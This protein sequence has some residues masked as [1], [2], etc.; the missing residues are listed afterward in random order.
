MPSYLRRRPRQV[1]APPGT[2]SI[3]G[4]HDQPFIVHVTRYGPDGMETGEL[5]P[6]SPLPD[7]R[8]GEVLWVDL[9][10]HTDIDE[11]TRI[12]RHYGVPPLVIEDAV[13]VG[14]RPKLD[15]LGESVFL[16]LRSISIL[17]DVDDLRREQIGLYFRDG[18]VLSFQEV[19][20]DVWESVRRR[21]AEPGSAIRR[22]GAD[23]LWYAL[24]DATVDAYYL[25]LDRIAEGIEGMEEEIFQSL[26]TD[27]PQRLRVLRKEAVALRRAAWPLR[28]A[29]DS[30]TRVPDERFGDETRLLLE[31]VRDHVRQVGEVNELM[32]EAIVANLDT[33]LSLVGMKQNE[34]MKVLTLVATIFIP[35]TFIAGIYGMNFEVMPELGFRY[36]YA[37]V[38]AVMIAVTIGMLI[39]FRRRNWL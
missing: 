29:M 9:V 8:E 28:E 2:I 22:S 34:I 18:L 3:G 20:G 21:L 4:S 35:L 5:E 16:S 12:A 33:Y 38:W 27:T 37:A 23:F 11:L 19:E 17:P 24:L 6:G 39:Y 15:I 14:Q 1:G 13:D 10:G 25:V 30:L 26:P 31:D 7:M 32:R 36:G